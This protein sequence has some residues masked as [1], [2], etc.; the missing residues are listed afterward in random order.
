MNAHRHS[1]PLPHD[2]LLPNLLG[3]SLPIAYRAQLDLDLAPC[4]FV[5]CRDGEEFH[6]PSE[7]RFHT[8]PVP[9]QLS[10]DYSTRVRFHLD[11]LSPVAIPLDVASTCPYLLHPAFHQTR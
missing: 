6:L 2:L 9:A 10:L 7:F 1:Y 8:Y 4:S 3:S 5:I 11:L